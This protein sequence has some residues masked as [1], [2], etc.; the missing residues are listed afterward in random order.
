MQIQNKIVTVKLQ[1]YLTVHL[2]K[3]Q[4]ATPIV[5]F[6]T[7]PFQKFILILLNCLFV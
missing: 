3:T 4:L 7:S 2:T 5:D 1:S 6:G